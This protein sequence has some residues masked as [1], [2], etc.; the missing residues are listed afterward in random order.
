MKTGQHFLESDPQ[1]RMSGDGQRIYGLLLAL[2]RANMALGKL[3][4]LR[5]VLLDPNL[6]A[7]APPRYDGGEWW[8]AGG[9]S[10]FSRTD[11]H[12]I[13]QTMTHPKRIREKRKADALS[14][15]GLKD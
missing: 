4:V 12:H 7:A 10:E 3:V 5:P 6:A 15:E 1:L 8:R 9:M 11:R 14:S 2:H 13:R